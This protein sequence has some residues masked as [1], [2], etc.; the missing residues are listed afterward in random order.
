MLSYPTYAIRVIL[1]VLVLV[2]M[3]MEVIETPPHHDDQ[4]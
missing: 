2:R 1:I 3:V 4:V